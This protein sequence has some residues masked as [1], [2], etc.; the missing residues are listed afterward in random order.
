MS[1]LD[2]IRLAL[3]DVYG[4]GPVLDGLTADDMVKAAVTEFGLDAEAYPGELAMLRGLVRTLRVIVRDDNAV[5]EARRLLHH[6]ADDEA[7][8]Y[9]QMGDPTLAR[10]AALLNAILQA[11]ARRWKSGRAISVLR[12]A[13]YHPVSPNTASHDL[14]ALAS[15]GHL[16]RHEEKGVR[17]YEVARR[18]PTRP[19]TQRMGDR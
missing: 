10:Q 14:A 13:G 6:H 15:A 9:E 8:A 3:T 18:S 5:A 12:E 19:N 1:A 4:T 7:A 16:V 17:W 2:D 11:P